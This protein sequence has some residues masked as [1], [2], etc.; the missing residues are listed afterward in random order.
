MLEKYSDLDELSMDALRELGNIGT[1]NAMTALSQMTSQPIDIAIPA[2]KIV[3]YQ[4]VPTLLGGVET[5]QMGIMLEIKGDLNGTFMFLLS[6]EFTKV[7]LEELLGYPI[8]DINDLDEMCESAICEIGNIMCCSYI[9]ALSSMLN[10]HVQV[11][12]PASCCDM[13]GSILSV[14][15]IQFANL[16]DELM[17]IENAFSYNSVSFISHILFLP[18]LESLNTLLKTLGLPY[19]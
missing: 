18:E 9:N 5:V 19:E 17:F 6:E 13:A 12:V 16:G 14:P 10:L 8:Q 15:M 3:P 11:S 2:V 1:G 7:M 4:D